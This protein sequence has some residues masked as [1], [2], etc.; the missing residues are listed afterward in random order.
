MGA[1]WRRRTEERSRPEG[2]EV[3]DA[4][5]IPATLA[6]ATFLAATPWLQAFTVPGTLA[7][8]VIASAASVSVAALAVRIWRQRPAMS[9]TVSALAFI[10][11]LFAACGVHPVAIWHGLARGPNRML[12][13]TLP[14]SG[15]RALLAAPLLLTWLCGTAT[16]EL[17]IR[18][19]RNR[20]GMMAAGLAIPVA[21]FVL[22]Y[23]VTVSG[24]GPRDIAA[25]LLLC[26]LALVAVSWQ[27]V[28]QAQSPRA[29]VGEAFEAEARPSRWRPGLVALASI[30]VIAAVL[31]LAVP[32]F[33]AMSRRPASAERT[34]SLTAASIVDPVDALAEFRDGASPTET[35]LQ[36]NTDQPSTG[37]LGMAVLD[38]YDGSTWSFD[39]TFRPTGGRIPASPGVV[40]GALSTGTVRQRDTILSSLPVPFLPALD[41]PTQVGGVEVAA[42]PATGMLLPDRAGSGP[43]AFTVESRAPIFT[44]ATVPA[45]DGIATGAGQ[46]GS[47]AGAIPAADLTLPPDTSS[48]IATALRSVA[49]STG[50]RP[51]PT[52]A[53]LQALLDQFHSE[54]WVDPHLDPSKDPPGSH[55]IRHGTA[56]RPAPA[57]TTTIGT[58]APSQS[59]VQSTAG[60]SLSEAISAVVVNGAATPEQFATLFALFARYLGVPARLVTG[61][62]IATRS[63]AGSLPAGKYRV[64]DRQ[65]WTWVEIPVAGIGWVVADPTPNT[66]VAPGSAP[67]L[68]AQTTPTTIPPRPASAVPLPESTGGHALTKPTQ[69][70]IPKSHHLRWWV[71]PITVL[72]GLI[73]LIALLGPGLAGARRLARRRARHRTEPAQLAVGAWLELLDGLQQAGMPPGR[74]DTSAEVAADVGSHF[75]PELAGPVRQVGALAERAVC[76]ITGPPDRAAATE[77]WES[78]RSLVRTIHRRLDRRQRLRALV[79]VGS[80]PRFPFE[81][82]EPHAGSGRRV[83]SSSEST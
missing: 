76:S 68:K 61:F 83:P 75:A 4:A 47:A 16:T 71:V 37:Y 30:A 26:A 64:T 66:A 33:P 65:A 77:A 57:T 48:V 78:Q 82:A 31:A 62:R 10:V 9:Y 56:G 25:P 28:R 54:N 20:S 34:P 35:V 40:A 69:V 49:S 8:F 18:A 70:R 6:V 59:K 73:L 63:D 79:S 46:G 36:V 23:A 1:I 5:V 72:I 45:A 38:D 42:D 27:V 55:R 39:T 29:I 32:S 81:K 14:I 11:L 15:G 13:E 17:V 51:A 74:G 58:T 12:T 24:P 44:L 21:T 60:T 7:L 41:R 43:R 2:I 80:A 3:I 22:A 53:F 52:I 19:R 50:L 67:P